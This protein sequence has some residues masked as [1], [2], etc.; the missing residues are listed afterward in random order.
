MKTIGFFYK[1]S[2]TKQ[3]PPPPPPILKPSS[4]SLPFLSSPPLS[5]LFSLGMD[6]G[7]NKRWLRRGWNQWQ[8]PSLFLDPVEGGGGVE[9]G[10]GS[11]SVGRER[12][13]AAATLP[14][15]SSA[16]ATP[17]AGSTA[18]VRSGDRK[19]WRGGGG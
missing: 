13:V 15:E 2:Y 9:G 12:S 11:G 4:H 7:Q 17:A 16:V 10:C 18:A 1:T 8:I 5:H 14:S 19:R 6:S 3:P